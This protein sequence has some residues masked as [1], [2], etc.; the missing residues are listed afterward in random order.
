MRVDVK[1][2]QPKR[3]WSSRI[4][5]PTLN[6]FLFD[7]RENLRLRGA[8]QYTTINLPNGTSEIKRNPGA[9]GPALF[10]DCLGERS[11]G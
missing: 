3:E 2:D 1:F 4:S 10:D 8:E 5:K 6:L 11:R 7:M 9:Y